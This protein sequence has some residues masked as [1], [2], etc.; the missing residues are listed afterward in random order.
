[1]K[2]KYERKIADIKTANEKAIRKLVEE[3][4][5]NLLKVQ[6]EMKEAQAATAKLKVYY[7]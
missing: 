5:V 3:F 6:D 1:M 4:K 2:Q 7:D